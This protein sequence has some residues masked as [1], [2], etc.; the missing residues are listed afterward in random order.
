MLALV[1]RWR[2]SLH[3][4]HL[5]ALV[6]G[7][8]LP[9]FVDVVVGSQVSIVKLKVLPSGRW[10]LVAAKLAHVVSLTELVI[11]LAEVEVA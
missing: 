8:L 2:F 5:I 3:L 9:L 11:E 4:G 7:L 1:V 6:V 10:P